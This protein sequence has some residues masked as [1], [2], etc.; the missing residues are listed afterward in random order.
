MSE[1]GEIHDTVDPGQKAPKSQAGTLQTRPGAK[2]GGVVESAATLGPAASSCTDATTAIPCNGV[3]CA[4]ATIQTLCAD[5]TLGVVGPREFVD[6]TGKVVNG[7][8]A[9][10][11][12]LCSSGNPAAF[13]DPSDV[14]LDYANFPF[15]RE[16]PGQYFYAVVAA[17][18]EDQGF[19][20][21]ARGNLSDTEPSAVQGDLGS[22]DALADR[23]LV[24][25]KDQIVVLFPSSHGTHEISFPPSQFVTI[26]LFP[27]DTTP[28][29]KYVLAVCPTSATSRCDC[30]FGA[31][32]VVHR[33]ADAGLPGTGGAGATGGAGGSGGKAARDASAEDASSAGG[34]SADAGVLCHDM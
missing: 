9:G 33:P 21:G 23:T 15:S 3:T 25:A 12:L 30:A 17:G 13:L 8:I 34:S 22:G 16:L 28:E 20:Q 10:N 26:Q 19:L 11:T 31:F 6:L 27:F 24:I 2:E 14:A 7:C 32:G 5:P 4:D 18:Y 29:G 1:L